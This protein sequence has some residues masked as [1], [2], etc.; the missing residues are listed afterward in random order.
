MSLVHRDKQSETVD[1][2]MNLAME[3]TDELMGQGGTGSEVA[4]ESVTFVQD[5]SVGVFTKLVKGEMVLSEKSKQ[6]VTVKVLQDKS[7]S[8]EEKCFLSEIRFFKAL[9]IHE[10]IISMLGYITAKAPLCIVFEYCPHGNLK[11]FLLD[12]HRE[13]RKVDEDELEESTINQLLQ[14]ASQIANGMDFLEKIG[15]V[16]RTLAAKSVHVGHGKV[17]KI[18][19]FGFSSIV[20]DVNTYEKLTKGRIPIRWMALESILECVYTPK[21]DVW[22]YGIVLWEIF[23][24]GNKPY[25]DMPIKDVIRELRHGYR[26]PAP[27][28]ADEMMYSLMNECWQDDPEVDQLLKNCQFYRTG[29][30]MN[31][32]VKHH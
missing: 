1:G 23:S 7:G 5:I 12:L 13:V 22:S 21:T 15:C 17:C 4:S 28:H 26:L 32:D 19:E 24:F 14:F 30:P 16:H 29:F 31:K 25:P 9:A 2:Q 6:V 27:K 18:A 11:D 8:D 20:M 10:N 3:H